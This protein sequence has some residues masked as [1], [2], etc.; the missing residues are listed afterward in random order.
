MIARFVNFHFSRLLAFSRALLTGEIILSKE[1]VGFVSKATP[2]IV[3]TG[4]VFSA[5]YQKRSIVFNTSKGNVRETLCSG[6]PARGWYGH[7]VMM[8]PLRNLQRWT[9]MKTGQAVMPALPGS[10]R[11]GDGRW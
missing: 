10:F 3:G 6:G 8:P 9:Y 7:G 5:L 1:S 2:G 11:W 4:K